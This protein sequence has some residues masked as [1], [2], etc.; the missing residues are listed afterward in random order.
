MNLMTGKEVEGGE[1]QI[2]LCF[3]ITNLG[4]Y[5]INITLIKNYNL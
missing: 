3:K 1:I 5:S 4:D 2:A